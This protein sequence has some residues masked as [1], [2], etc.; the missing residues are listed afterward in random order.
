MKKL[1]S[2][3]LLAGTALMLAAS[4]SHGQYVWVDEKG[5]RQYSDRAPPGSTPIKKILKSPTPIKD[6][7]VEVDP[8]LAAKTATKPAAKAPATLQERE[9]D[10]R[11]RSE[12]KAKADAEAAAV[13]ANLAQRQ[14]ACNAARA[15]Q[16]QLASGRRMRGADGGFMDNNQRAAQ[17]ARANH[18]LSECNN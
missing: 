14:A 15:S 13:A 17:E 5:I 9:A 11:K 2:L 8:L 12:E 18:L 7:V 4:L 10:Y 3:Q 16:A 6:P 1:T